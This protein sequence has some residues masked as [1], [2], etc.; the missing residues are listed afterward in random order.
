LAQVPA[1]NSEARAA[2]FYS[3]AC[4]MRLG[5]FATAS[6]LL[7][8]VADAGDSPQ[9]EAALYDLAQIALAGNDPVTAHAYLLRTISLRGDLE[10]RAREQDGRITELVGQ[11]NGIKRK[12]PEVK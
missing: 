5:D 6:G 3:G 8:K 9:Q 4:Q 2:E 10:G 7:R 12:N 11:E 1:E